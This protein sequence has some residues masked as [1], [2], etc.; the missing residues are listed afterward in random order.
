[1]SLPRYIVNMQEGAVHLLPNKDS[2]G[3]EVYNFEKGYQRAKGLRLKIRDGVGFASWVTDRPIFITGIDVS[4][5]YGAQEAP[6]KRLDDTMDF[7]IGDKSIFKD[8]PI[9]RQEDYTNFRTYAAV[10]LGTELTFSYAT[11]TQI[12]DLEED[13]DVWVTI[14][15]IADPVLQRVDFY[16]IDVETEEVFK[17]MTMHISKGSYRVDA[18]QLE[19]YYA[20]ELVKEFEVN[21]IF[22][23]Q[24]NDGIFPVNFYYEKVGV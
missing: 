8:K 17:Q 10:N 14:D 16:C 21:P 15:Y 18:P 12:G 5:E 20:K 23:R 7:S 1:M 6:N 3:K 13:K 2:E 4:T 11:N 19:G 22:G 24:T 9:Y